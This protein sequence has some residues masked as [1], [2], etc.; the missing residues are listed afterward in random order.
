MK[1]KPLLVVLV[2]H[3]F[4][5]FLLTN[6]TPI[7]AENLLKNP[8]FE[9][10]LSGYIVGV[11]GKKGKYTITPDKKGFAVTINAL[12]G[13]RVAL[14]LPEVYYR[15]HTEYELSFNAK[16]S[17]GKL[18]LIVSEYVTKKDG[19]HGTF[20]PNLTTDWKRYSY[21][22][23]TDAPPKW[24]RPRFTTDDTER[25]GGF[26]I[27]KNSGFAHE[28]KEFSIS[29]IYF[30]PVSGKSEIADVLAGFVESQLP[31]TQ[32]NG[33]KLTLPIHFFNR[34]SQV[35]TVKITWQL[36][37]DYRDAVSASG[38]CTQKLAP[39]KSKGKLSLRLP[40]LN[41]LCT[42]EA[43][44]D[45]R[46]FAN[47]IR[48][49]VSPKVRVKPGELPVDLGINS[50]ATNQNAAEL[51][52]TEMEFLADSGISFIRTWD[53]GNPFSWN[54]I[55]PGR[56]AFFWTHA[57]QLVNL[58]NKAGIEV[59]PVLGGMFFVYPDYNPKRPSSH[60]APEWVYQTGQT[61][62]CPP[63]M[64]QFTRL[65][66]KTIL[67]RIADWNNMIRTIVERYKGKVHYYEIMNE[68]NLCL[69]AEQYLIYLKNA[70]TII[71]EAAP[72]ARILGVSATGDYNA[73]IID[74]VDE[75]LKLGAA[76]HFD[77]ISFHPYN[78]LYEDSRKPGDKVIA[79]YYT[80]LKEN[81]L[82]NVRLWNTELYYLN[83]KTKGG[84]D[85]ANGPIFHPGYLARR[86][87]LDAAK[88]V[89][90]SI[91]VPGK[92][93]LGNSFNA[94]YRLER[95]GSFF[96]TRLFPSER[97]IVNAVFADL[98]KGTRF[99]GEAEFKN[100]IKIYKF[101]K[102]GKAVAAVFTLHSD[103]EDEE[104]ASIP[105]PEK[106]IKALDVF[107]NPL[108]VKSGKI[109][110]PFSPIPIYISAKNP[111]TLD[112]YL[113]NVSSLINAAP[114]KA[115]YS[116]R[117]DVV[118]QMELDFGAKQKNCT[119]SRMGWLKDKSAVAKTL[120]INGR[121]PLDTVNYTPFSFS[122]TPKADGR[123]SIQL[124]GPYRKAANGLEKLWVVYG[125]ICATPRLI[126]GGDFA[127][128]RA[129]EKSKASAN[130]RIIPA[131]DGTNDVRVWHNGIAK[132]NIE[133]N[134]GEL[135]TI[136]FTAK[137]PTAK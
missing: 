108:A 88:G 94:N 18:P 54:A 95:S 21:R 91:L 125:Q 129:W 28:N 35:K 135:V 32:Q 47:V 137:A 122:F 70:G 104:T 67:P 106:G 22:F 111:K 112:Q 96:R 31:P 5:S 101:A 36:R 77:D 90:A 71:R 80:F 73:H 83:P 20:F 103:I 116:C 127:E 118:G 133:V 14:Y 66:R 119:A 113:E 2:L 50:P 43:K 78:N 82:S 56:N 131:P 58:A 37:L 10:G 13:K 46:E 40:K 57:D 87:L 4:T 26:R 51:T 105:A 41:G 8:H 117:I 93:F 38:E 65:G 45:D 128:S 99:S 24:K 29:D 75:T 81:N 15:P 84:S 107:G 64:P 74:Y 11:P 52:E 25:M 63:N 33:R 132:Q 30:G 23:N 55:E 114:A 124:K 68:P 120:S 136:S 86:Y 100:R 89:K 44:I 3:G 126:K 59:L 62:S 1:K 69:T 61:V 76:T 9:L 17:S 121:K 134:K 19:S 48:L 16:C 130:A 79:A 39:G 60:A 53:G 115:N 123:V 42:L 109:Q 49:A 98:L 92:T 85:H 27:V 34:G 6:P 102:A 12:S 110:F 97:Y 7:H 72:N